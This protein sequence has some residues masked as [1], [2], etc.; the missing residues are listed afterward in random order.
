M[1][2]DTP[3]HTRPRSSNALNSGISGAGLRG[4]SLSFVETL[5][6]SIANVAPTLT[7]A[8]NISVV[9]GIAGLGAWLS[10]WIATIALIFVAANIGI[11]A[12]R[13]TLA[14]SYFLYIGRSLGPLPGMLAGWSMIAAYLFTASAASICADIFLSDLLH[15][16]DLERLLPSYAI[17]EIGFISLIWVCAYRDVRLSS[18]VGLALEA[19][20][21]ARE[22]S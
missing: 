22:Y 7:P 20:S 11:L 17:F 2:L 5:G 14:G 16:L 18:R 6:Q 3:V 1:L 12:R 9:V 15:V 10:Y 13:H 21:L 8:L 4:D 19:L